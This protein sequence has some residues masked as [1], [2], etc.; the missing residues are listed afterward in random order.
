M[1]N[2][3]KDQPSLSCPSSNGFRFQSHEW[4]KHGACSESQLDQHEYFEAALNLKK[5]ANLLQI[6]RIARIEPDDGFYRLDNIVKAIIK[7]IGH[8]PRIGCNKDSDGNR[9][10]ANFTKSTSVWTVLGQKSSSVQ[11]LR[12]EDVLQMFSF[13]SSK[14]C[15]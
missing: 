9:L 15:G 1:T 8:T 11:C 12:K 6:L 3:Q 2:L 14:D 5:K 10:T 13:R 7:G 4:E